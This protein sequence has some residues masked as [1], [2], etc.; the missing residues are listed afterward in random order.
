[1]GRQAVRQVVACPGPR[2]WQWAFLVGQRGWQG[3]QMHGG[4]SFKGFDRLGYLVAGGHVRA[5]GWLV[6]VCSSCSNKF[7]L[8]MGHADGR[9]AMQRLGLLLAAVASMSGAAACQAFAGQCVGMI[10]SGD[11]GQHVSGGEERP[12]RAC[13]HWALYCS[14]TLLH[15]CVTPAQHTQVARMQNISPA[16]SPAAAPH[17]RQC[18]ICQRRTQAL[19]VL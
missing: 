8:F 1:M 18:M 6:S 14:W 5:D 16:A 11:G 10:S 3:L 19:A 2:L 12:G 17:H 13:G 7:Q 9:L 15:G 4:I